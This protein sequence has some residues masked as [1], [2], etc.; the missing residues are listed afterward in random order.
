MPI[1]A[2]QSMR[3][4]LAQSLS[5][6]SE[7]L[8]TEVRKRAQTSKLRKAVAEALPLGS[9]KPRH[10]S[11]LAHFRNTEKPKH[12]P[13]AQRYRWT[14]GSGVQERTRSHRIPL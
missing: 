2:R 8:W 11:D 7:D 10:R 14:D 4:Y 5:V 6:L 1:A 13:S 3:A 9:P 12:A